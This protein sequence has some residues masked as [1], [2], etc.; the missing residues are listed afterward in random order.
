MRV[1]SVTLLMLCGCPAGLGAKTVSCAPDGGL[2]GCFEWSGADLPALG[3]IDLTCSQL[4]STSVTEACPTALRETG[5]RIERGGFVETR[6]YR[7]G[8]GGE[9]LADCADAGRLVVYADDV[10]GGVEV[11]VGDAGVK[12]S[13]AGGATSVMTFLNVTSD[14]V[15]PSWVTPGTCAEF[16]YPPLAPG[17]GV[18][19]PTFIGHVW[20]FRRGPG[21]PLLREYVVDTV[22]GS[23]AIR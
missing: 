9:V 1:V 15:V 3:A 22:S 19:Q 8:T 5:C 23:V 20:R 12:C 7:L 4:G 11:P 6:W 21:G 14:P 13:T 17:A 10:D 2:L 18:N 16:A